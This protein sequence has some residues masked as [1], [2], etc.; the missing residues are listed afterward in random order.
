MSALYNPE[1]RISYFI[2]T[3]SAAAGANVLD[4]AYL[5]ATLAIHTRLAE[6]EVEAADPEDGVVRT[7]TLQ[8]LC[9]LQPG[10]EACAID[11]ILSLWNFDLATLQADADVLAT[12]NGRNATDPISIQRQ[13]GGI[14]LDAATGQVQQNGTLSKTL[15]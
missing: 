4:K 10:T 14:E 6:L 8:D 2:T 11:S 5:Q 3:P 15:M 1:P 12:I 13:L 7:W 9:V